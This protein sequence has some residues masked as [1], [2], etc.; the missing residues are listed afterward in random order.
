MAEEPLYLRNLWYMAAL[1]SSLKPGAMRREV[2]LGEPVLLARAPDGHAFA[3]RDI[4]P[5][6]AAPLS[7]GQFK[8]GDVECPYHGWRFNAGGQ[9]TQIPSLLQD[10]NFDVGRIRVRN[11]PLK[12][13]D[14]LIWIYM[15]APGRETET[16]ASDP[17]KVGV[18]NAVPR[19]V[20]SQTFACGIDHAVV[21]LMDPSHAPYV[22]GRWWWKVKPKVKEKRYAPLPTGFVMTRHAPSKP[23]YKLFGGDVSTEITFELPSVR[24]ENIS[25][26][27]FGRHID[28][29]GFT[30]CTPIDGEKTQVTQVFYWPAWLSF[31]KPL[32]M[33]LGPIFLGDDRK[34]VEL[35]RQGLQFNPNLMLIQDADVPAI[36]Y[37]RL[38]KAW[39]ESVDTGKPFENP[40]QERTLRWRS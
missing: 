6:R 20:E 9:C 22:H 13:Q 35:Q 32:F 36:W 5:H 28:V 18:P 39:A 30:A 29:V 27:L 11:Y 4:C 21:G 12:E 2:L 16:P 25:G 31:V 10:Q 24:F 1:S 23:A 34:M 3:L 8:E 33:V 17:P 26:T 40:V 38:K 15:A 37:H 7:A 19:W 14:G